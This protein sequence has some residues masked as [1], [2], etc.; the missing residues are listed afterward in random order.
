MHI[1]KANLF[2]RPKASKKIFFQR[3]LLKSLY[4]ISPLVLMKYRYLIYRGSLPNLKDPKTFDEKLIWLNFYWRHPLKTVCGDKYEMRGYVEKHGLSHILTPLLGVYESPD[5]IDFDRLPQRFV[6]KCSHGC[7]YNIVCTDRQ[8]F[9][10]EVSKRKLGKWL[11]ENFSRIYGEMHYSAMKPRI[12][13]EVFLED[14]SSKLPIDYK[15]YCFDGKVHCTMICAGREINAR[16]KYYIF[17]DSEWKNKLPYNKQSIQ[18]HTDFPAPKS[19][20]EMIEAAER[21]SAPFP[22]VRMDFYSIKGKAVLGEMTF[23]PNGCIDPNLTEIAQ[24]VMGDLILLP[25]KYT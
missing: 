21:L 7:G 9:D 5:E 3:N 18:G 25:E 13:S 19:Y 12:I 17:Y 6:L 15:V 2:L 4:T 22:F 11:S 1:R 14:S 10:I 23:T 16:A 20:K 8:N 24:R